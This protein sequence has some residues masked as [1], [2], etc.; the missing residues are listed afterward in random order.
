VCRENE[1]KRVV[2]PLVFATRSIC[3]RRVASADCRS[4]LLDELCRANWSPI[5]ARRSMAARASCSASSMPTG[6]NA[7]TNGADEVADESRSQAAMLFAWLRITLRTPCGASLNSANALLNSSVPCSASSV[8]CA[9]EIAPR[10]T[11]FS[12][13]KLRTF[14]FASTPP[15]SLPTICRCARYRS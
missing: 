15:R 14:R 1:R 2:Y 5:A 4:T 8:V 12:R 3:S 9:Q 10:S 6:A 7:A 11:T 13:K